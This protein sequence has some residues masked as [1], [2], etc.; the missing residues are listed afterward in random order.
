MNGK[1]RVSE[2]VILNTP[3]TPI[4]LITLITLTL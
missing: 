3:N 2:S 4:T 1:L